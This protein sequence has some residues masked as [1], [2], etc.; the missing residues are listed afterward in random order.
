MLTDGRTGGR[1][2]KWMETG[3]LYRTMPEAGATK[4]DKKNIE[5]LLQVPVVV[6]AL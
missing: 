4:N 2:Y 3:T 6:H 1:A 5:I